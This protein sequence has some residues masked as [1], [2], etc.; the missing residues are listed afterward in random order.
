MNGFIN[1][2]LKINWLVALCIFIYAVKRKEKSVMD[3]TIDEGTLRTGSALINA[4]ILLKQGVELETG[5]RIRLLVKLINKP[6][7]L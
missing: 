5:K 1:M 6:L 3:P 2:F 4:L 7:S